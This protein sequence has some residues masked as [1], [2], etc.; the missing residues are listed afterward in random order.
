MTEVVSFGNY[1][2]RESYSGEKIHIHNVNNCLW[3]NEG[4]FR[5]NERVK[6]PFGNNEILD[7][8]YCSRKCLAE[9]P[10]HIIYIETFK[11]QSESYKIRYLQQEQKENRFREEAEQ[12]KSEIEKAKMRKYTFFAIPFAIL[13]ILPT[14][15]IDG[16]EGKVL[17]F[18]VAIMIWQ[19]FR[20]FF[21]PK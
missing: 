19:L 14:F 18:L 6:I 8:P 3:C 12:R 17:Y 1:L 2:F 13:L 15:L 4:F 21:S 16:G 11:E 9:D 10:N 20:V 7:I 5:G